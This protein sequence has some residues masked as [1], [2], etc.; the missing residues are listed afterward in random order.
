[1]EN[2]TVLS[3]P[4]DKAR[5][6]ACSPSCERHGEPYP[7]YGMFFP[8]LVTSDEGFSFRHEDPLVLSA[9]NQ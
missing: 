4:R 8:T 7:G 2:S 3:C 1:M 5:V 6:V 9:R